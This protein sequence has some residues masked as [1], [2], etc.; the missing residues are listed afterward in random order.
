MKQEKKRLNKSDREILKQYN[1]LSL[2]EKEIANVLIKKMES[3]L[4]HERT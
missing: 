1:F 2:S 3:L 4:C